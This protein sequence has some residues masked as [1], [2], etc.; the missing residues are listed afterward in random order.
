MIQGITPGPL[1]VKEHPALLWGVIFSMYVGNV[2]LLIINLP[3]IGLWVRLL[4]VPYSLLFPLIV[5]VCM[6]GGYAVRNTTVDLCLMLIF[7]VLGYLFRKFE[8]EPAPLV[9]AFV[10]SSI[11]D[12]TLR[13]SLIISKGN[14]SIFFVRPISLGCLILAALVLGSSILS[15]LRRSST[16]TRAEQA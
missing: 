13:Q 5:L 10:L 6:I 2:M 16:Q 11:F 8:Y 12:E 9:L 14:F 3:L 1:L 15:S 7:G 4:R